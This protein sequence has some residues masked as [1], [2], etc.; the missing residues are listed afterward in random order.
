MN[1]ILIALFIIVS[2]AVPPQSGSLDIPRQRIYKQSDWKKFSLKEKIAQMIMVRIRGDYYNNTHWYKNTLKKWLSEDAVGGV[3]TFGGSIHG[4]YYN[5]QKLQE[6]ARYPVLVAA[7][8]ERG[9]GQWM[10]GATLFPSN[11]ALAATKDSKLAYEQGRITALEA[12]AL[13][14]Q[15]TFSPVMDINNNPENPII[16]FRSYSDD[17]KLV[18]KFG[19]AFIRGAQNNGLIACAK[20]FPGHGNTN[21]DSHTRLPTIDGKRAELDT[22]E[23]YPFRESLNTKIEMIMVGH[24]ALTGLDKSGMPASHSYRVTS[25]LLRDELGFDGIIITDGMEMGGLTE[26]SWAGES[27]IRAVEAGADILLLPIDVDQTINSLLKSVE[28]GRL[29][30]DR[31]DQSV[32]RIWNMK[33][34]TGLLD[35]NY[36]LPFE[37]LENIIGDPEHKKI[38]RTIA[39]KSITVVKDDNNQLPLH[40]EQI[41]SLAHIILSLDEGAQDYLKLFNRDIHRTH[42]HVKDIFVNNPLTELGRQDIQNQLEGINQAII[43]ILVRIRM[44]KGISTIDSTHSLLLSELKNLGIPMVAFSFGSPYLPSYKMLDTYVC[45][46][47]YGSISMKAAADALWGRSFVNGVLPVNLNSKYIRGSGI[48]KKKRTNTWGQRIQTDFPD[49]WKILDSAIEDKIFPGAQVFIAK[50]G[51]ILYSGGYGHHTYDSGS[52]PVTTESIYDVAS[53]TKVLSITPVIMKL[54]SQKKLSL[55]QHVYHFLPDFTGGYKKDVTIRHLLTH[56]SGIKP[57][58]RFFK[59]EK[60]IDR[61]DVINEIINLDLEFQPGSEYSYSD[62]GMMLLMEIAEMVSRRSLDDMAETWLYRPLSM[63]STMY[64]PEKALLHKIVP[65]EFDSLYRGGLVHGEVHDENTY[66]I[67]GVSSHAGL[68]STAENIGNYAQMFI[69]NGTWLGK[70]IFKESIIRE[71]TSRQFLPKDSDYALGWDTPTQNGTSSAGDYF[72]N[73]SFGHLGFTGTSMWID[74]AEE[75]III[76]LT[77]RVH[78]TRNRGGIYSIRREFHNAVMAQLLENS[79]GL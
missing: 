1:R 31:I 64:K 27:A 41:D 10:N 39:Q 43:S 38:A 71:F 25:E 7:D 4:S 53:L 30:E 8:Y 35:G 52:A 66:L 49:V 28:S 47:N 63:R 15:V 23:L 29:S 6:W 55:D 70:R 60:F 32:R 9:L 24:I 34:K 78:P 11:M 45:T 13:G 2:C 58:Q 54:I 40:V 74:P 73:I 33:Y 37:K 20:H 72:S 62:L 5:I 79:G 17:P 12:K 36:Q 46:F 59:D 16:N 77:N 26:S 56:S 76:L 44:D 67:G 75:I 18:S 48:S 61:A 68:F 42:G 3:I 22:M 21:T 69:N 50:N 14:V 65:T 19:S 51:N 57:Y